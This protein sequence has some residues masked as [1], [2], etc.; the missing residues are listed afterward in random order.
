MLMI[1]KI[2][3]GVVMFAALIAL[4]GNAV[5]ASEKTELVGVKTN[6]QDISLYIKGITDEVTGVSCQIGTKAEQK[7]EYESVADMQKP[8]KTL[9]MIDNS[10]SI[11]EQNRVKITAFLK[12][13]LDDKD[14]NELVAIY[15][16]SDTVTSLIDFTS[17]KE[18]LE[19]AVDSMEYQNQDTYLTDVLY[20]VLAQNSM[21][22]E[23]CYRKIIIIS[24]GV[25]SKTIGYTKEELFSLVEEKGY[26]IYTIGCIYKENNEQLENMFALSRQS[27]AKEFMLDE[28]EDTDDMSDVIIADSQAV[29]FTIMPE[30]ADM[31]GSTKNILITIQTETGN[32][33]VEVTAKMPLVAQS[34]EKVKE[35]P[36]I[37][38]QVA[39]LEATEAVPKTIEIEKHFEIP[40]SWIVGSIGILLIVVTA[41]VGLIL[42]RGKKRLES[43][44]QSVY[45]DSKQMVDKTEG[46]SSKTEIITGGGNGETQIIWGDNIGQCKLYLTDIKVPDKKFEYAVKESIVVGRKRGEA[47]IVIDYDSSVSG[48][49]CEISERNGKYYLRDLQSSNGTYLNGNKITGKVEI[50]SGCI[51]SLGKRVE[52]KLEIK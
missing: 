43:S 52:M 29:H 14:K 11:T 35:T 23:D 8:A 49:H 9:F 32:Q 17:D 15:T 48:T 13:Y 47:D 7:I 2:L 12:N 37:A 34:I 39:P 22:E 50:R 24:D 21:G 4:T 28:V 30:A 44:R 40:I 1:K 16:F 41:I 19:A 51:I 25:D 26:P 18:Q 20:D 10:L 46:I 36:I 33:K 45:E 27:A 38:E 3:R 42:L 5:I 31:D 6:E